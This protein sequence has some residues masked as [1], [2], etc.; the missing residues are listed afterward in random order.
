M[1]CYSANNYYL[2]SN[3]VTKKIKSKIKQFH[4]QK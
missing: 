1:Y 4:K 3:K 2:C